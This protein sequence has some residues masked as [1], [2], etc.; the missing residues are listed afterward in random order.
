MSLTPEFIKEFKSALESQEFSAN[1]Q[2]Q[3]LLNI[4]RA[5]KLLYHVDTI[6]CKFFLVHKANRGFLMLSPHNCHRNAARIE[7]VGADMKQLTNALCV[8]L[9]A[10]GQLREEH[11]SKNKELVKRAGGLLPEVNGFE[12]Y[13]TLGAGHTTAFCKHAAVCGR[14]SETSLQQS[15][16]TL[17]DQ[18]KLCKNPQFGH[19]I[20]KG[21]GWD[22][23]PAS[24]DCMFPR[25]AHIAQ[26]A[27]NT[28]NHVATVMGELETSMIME[29][30]MQDA[31]GGDD[32]SLKCAEKL[33]IA[34]VQSLAVPCSSYCKV[35]LDFALTYGGGTGAPHIVFMDAVQKQFGCN[36][37]L[38]A[39]FWEAITTTKFPRPSLY[40]M[41]RVALVL[42][43]LTSDKIEDNVA[44]LLTKGD[45]LKVSK[46]KDLNKWE[47][48]LQDAMVI[49]ESV[50]GFKV[51]LKPLGQLFVRVA[52]V[53]ADKEKHGREKKNYTLSE[54]KTLFLVDVGQLI[55]R[56]VSFVGWDE[57]RAAHSSSTVTSSAQNTAAAASLDALY[58]WRNKLGYTWV[59]M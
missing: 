25:F 53:A 41:V 26:K 6:H 18:Q 49:A 51:V 3:N 17:I 43:N 20:H 59:T 10:S 46:A 54:I 47:Q 23:V 24:V 21:W 52:L 31:C 27:L 57:P 28:S 40:P 29:T 55:D 48:V 22:V 44:K 39:A 5:H 8:E 1:E 58:S 56:K 4:L 7:S 33:A 2:L 9:A 15:G 19:M 50:G 38:G 11:I 35:L 42:A 12:R 30:S 45:I 37:D 16:S 34:N 36:I 32:E 13:L 14:T